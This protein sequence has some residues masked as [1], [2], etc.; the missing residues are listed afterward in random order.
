M[1]MVEEQAVKI[2]SK[3]YVKLLIGHEQNSVTKTKSLHYLQHSSTKI[4]PIISGKS[5]GTAVYNNP[6]KNHK[7]EK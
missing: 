3:I 4:Q 2:Q 6:N 5:D 1:A 7:A